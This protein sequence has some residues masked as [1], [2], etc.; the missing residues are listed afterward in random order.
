MNAED[1]LFR[2]LLRW[3]PDP[4]IGIP[5][6]LDSIAPG[7][8]L[9]Q[10]IG[11]WGNWFNQELYG[12]PTDLP[13]GLEIAPEHRPAAYATNL[14]KP[15]MAWPIH[16]AS[17][18]YL[19]GTPAEFKAALGESPVQMIDAVPGTTKTPP[20]WMNRSRTAYR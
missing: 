11:R 5:D 6:L 17:N 2:R 7:L 13:W 15:K 4:A 20:R 16:Y 18:P 1:E 19:K 3:L 10:A 8:L 9:A 12:R 14:I